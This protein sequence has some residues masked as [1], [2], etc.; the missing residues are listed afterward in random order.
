MTKVMM[1][2]CCVVFSMAGVFGQSNLRPDDKTTAYLAGFRTVYMQSILAKKPEQ[3]QPFYAANL[4]LM[5]EFQKTM[6]GKD[7]VLAYHK[8]FAARF[9]IRELTRK[10]MEILDFGTRVAEFGT[11]AM[12]ISVKANGQEQQLQ[13]KYMDIWEKAPDGTLLLTTQAWNYSHRIPDPEQ[14]RFHD[15][16]VINIAFEP[17]VP[18]NNNISYEL[19]AINSL[20]EIAVTQH[21]AKVWSLHYADDVLQQQPGI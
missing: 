13:G 18:I 6:R 9:D 15:L 12:R 19:A 11:F 5:P 17:H 7:N 8:A 14:V 21:D 20:H 16:L 2:L 3:L 10:E 1:T 4:R